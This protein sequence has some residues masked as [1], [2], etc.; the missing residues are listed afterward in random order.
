M[1]VNEDYRGDLYDNIVVDGGTTCLPGFAD[2]LKKEVQA[3]APPTMRTRVIAR[4]ERT[5]LS[6]VGGSFLGSL[7]TFQPM[8]ITKAEYDE[9]GASIVHRKC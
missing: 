1:N 2:R 9:A 4:P 5:L 7:S 8:W 6:W 3:L